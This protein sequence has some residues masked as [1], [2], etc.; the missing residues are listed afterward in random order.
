[1]ESIALFDLVVECRLDVLGGVAGVWIYGDAPLLQQPFGNVAPIPVLPA[2]LAHSA[3]KTYVSGVSRNVLT[4]RSNSVASTGAGGMGRPQLGLPRLRRM[5]GVVAGP[6]II[7]DDT[8]SKLLLPDDGEVR[9]H[10]GR[11]RKQP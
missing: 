9:C 5:L 3:E 11:V 10:L 4:C 6:A 8:P 7:P 2:P 1:M